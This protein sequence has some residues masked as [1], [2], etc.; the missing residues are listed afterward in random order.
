MV[1]PMLE[2][3]KKIFFRRYFE[4]IREI[5]LDMCINNIVKSN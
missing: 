2:A 4:D 1:I 3:L 5:Y